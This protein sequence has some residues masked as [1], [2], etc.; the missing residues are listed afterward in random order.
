MNV[1][2][3]TK[4][5]QKGQIVI[6]KAIR[7]NL[8]IEAE[9][10]FNIIVRGQGIYLYPISEVIGPVD[11]ENSYL[12]ILKKTKG[13]WHNDNWEETVKARRKI[14][15]KAAKKRKELW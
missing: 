3:I 9:S 15:L 7:D 4:S 10:S 5:N 1:G 12:E 6:P 14:E 8:G 11:T 2:F 13:A